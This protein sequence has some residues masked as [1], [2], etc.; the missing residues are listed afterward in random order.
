[1][2]LI[3]LFLLGV[4]GA[5]AQS[6]SKASGHWQ[7]KIMIPDHELGFSVDLAKDARGV[8]I[9]SLKLTESA[10]GDVPL[11]EITVEGDAVRFAANLPQRASFNGNLSADATAISGKASNKDGEAPFS[12]TRNG[13]ANVKV[14]PPPSSLTKEFEGNWIGAVQVGGATRQIQLKLTRAAD[15]SAAG[16]LTV[17]EKSFDIPVTTVVIADKQLQLVVAAVSGKY[18]GTL[19]AGGEITGEWSEGPSTTYSLTFKRVP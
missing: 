9:G 4:L 2:K 3:A 14:P 12:L 18:Q 15:G 1:M 5:A 7:G 19:G 6:N 13:D 10:A 17:V 16:V 8:W 11:Q